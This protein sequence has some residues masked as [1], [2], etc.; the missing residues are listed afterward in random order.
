MKLKEIILKI[1]SDKEFRDEFMKSFTFKNNGRAKIA[2]K[3]NLTAENTRLA[4]VYLK[5]REGIK[6]S[7]KMQST[8]EEYLKLQDKMPI[9][10]I[11]NYLKKDFSTIRACYWYSIG[12]SMNFKK[13]K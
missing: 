9:T 7:S 6:L 8:Y 4:I 1:N 2:E 13:N 11:A 5:G 10:A 12:D 3:F